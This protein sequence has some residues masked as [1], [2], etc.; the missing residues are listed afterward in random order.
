MRLNA[1]KLVSLALLVFSARALADPIQSGVNFLLQNQS[2]VGAFGEAVGEEPVVTTYEALLTLR[3]TG[4]GALS[5]AQ[6]AELYL[7]TSLAPIDSELQL[8]RELALAGSGFALQP[9]ELFSEGPGFE[10]S[11]ALH[12]SLSLKAFRQVSL[13]PLGDAQAAAVQLAGLARADGCYAFVENDPSPE[14]TADIVSAFRSYSFNPNVNFAYQAALNCLRNLQRGD[15]SW[16]SVTSTASAVLALLESSG[17]NAVAISSGRNF[18]IATQLANGSWPGGVRATA[19]ATHALIAG[20]PDWR[21]TTDE[22]GRPALVLS[23]PEPLQGTTFTASFDVENR[24][25]TAAPT[26]NVRFIGNLLSGGPD[27]VLANIFIPPLSAGQTTN[28][29]TSLPTAQLG[30]RYILRAIVNPDNTI[31]ELDTTNNTAA[32]QLNVRQENDLAVSAAGIRFTTLGPNQVQVSV[33]V[34]NYGTTLPINVGVD[35]YKGSPFSGGTRV[36]S[37]TINAGLAPNQGTTVTVNW[38]T[39]TVNGPTAVYAFVDP[40]TQLVEADKNNNIAFRFFYPGNQASTDLAVNASEWTVSPPRPSPRQRFTVSVPV[41]NL[42]AADANRVQVTIY[43]ASSGDTLSQVELSQVPATGITVAQFAVSLPFVAALRATVDPQQLIQDP[44]RSNNTDVLGSFMSSTSDVELTMSDLNASSTPAPGGTFTVN[45]SVLNS[46][47]Q[48]ANTSIRLVDETDGRQLALV[49]LVLPGGTSAS[50]PMGPIV[51]LSRPMS[52][53]AC[54]DP[55]NLISEVNK[56]D[57]CLEVVVSDTFADV[58]LRAHDIQIAPVGADVGESVHLSATFRSNP[59]VSTS[60]VVEWWQ[61]RPTN[62]EGVLIGT[63]PIQINAGVGVA[64]FD[65]VRKDGV[66]EVHARMTGDGVLDP[67]RRNNQ[68]GRHL[69]LDSIVDVGVPGAAGEELRFGR[70]TGRAAP[71]MVLGYSFT[72]PGPFGATHSWIAVLQRNP[73]GS[74]AI[75]WQHELLLSIQDIVLGDLDGDGIPEVVAFSADAT[76]TPV[77]RITAYEPDGSTKWEQNF[78]GSNGCIASALGQTSRGL[79][80]GDVNGDGVADLVYID[81]NLRVFSGRDGA[82]LLN[83]ALTTSGNCVD[84]PTTVLDVDGTGAHEIFG[85]TGNREAFLMNSDGT[86]RWR[87]PVPGGS[88]YAIIDLDLSGSP[89]IVFPVHRNNLIAFDALTGNQVQTGSPF[90]SH[91]APFGIGSVRQDGLPYVTMGDNSFDSHAAA[92]GPDLQLIW[93]QFNSRFNASDDIAAATTTLA[94]LLG[95]GRPQLLLHNAANPLMIEDGRDGRIL[96]P[97]VTNTLGLMQF[98][99]MHP[100]TAVDFRGDGRSGVAIPTQT[101][102]NPNWPGNQGVDYAP[103]QV[104]IFSSPHWNK[105]P[106][107]WNARRIVK[108]RVDENLRVSTDYRW[109]RTNNTWNQQFDQQPVVLLADLLVRSGDISASPTPGTSGNAT[110]ITAQISNVGGLAASNV[111]VSFYDGDPNAGGRLIADSVVAGPL[112]PRTGRAPASVTWT[113]YPEGQ[114]RLFVVA[115]S[116]GAIQESGRENNTASIAYFVQPGTQLCDLAIDPTGLSANPSAPNA[117]DSVSLSASVKNI[118]VIPCGATAL[119]VY[120]GAPAEGGPLVGS[121]PIPSLAVQQS[122]VFTVSTI[123]EPGTHLFRFIADE[124]MLV[125]DGDRS[126]NTAMLQLFVPPSSTSDLIVTSLAAAPNPAFA[127]ETVVLSATVRNLGASAGATDFVVTLNSSTGTVL[128][129]GALPPLRPGETTNLSIPIAA[130]AASSQLFLTVNP[131]RRVTEFNYNNNTLSVAFALADPGLVVTGSANPSSAG[132][133][134]NVLFTVRLQ[135][136]SPLAR[137]VFVDASAIAPSGA[138]QSTLASSARYVVP[139]SSITT[140]NLTWNTGTSSPGAYRL[141]AAVRNS[142]RQVAAVDASVVVTAEQLVT[143]SIVT[144]RGSYAPGGTVL[145]NQRAS[146]ASR[147]QTLTGATLTVSVLDAIGRAL[148][149]STRPVPAIPPQG[150]LDTADLFSIS[151]SL[152][153]GNYTA[154]SRLNDALGGLLSQAQVGWQLVYQATQTVTGTETVTSP[155]AVGQVLGVSVQ[156]QNTGAVALSNGQLQATIFNATSFAPEAGASIA[157]NLAAGQTQTFVVNVNTAAISTGPKLVVASLDGRVLDRVMAQAVPQIHINPPVI[158]VRGVS[159]LLV[160]NQAVTPTITITSDSAFTSIILLDSQ[161]YVSGT[162]VSSNG[163]HV[164]FISATDVFGNHAEVAIRFT[165]STAAPT[166]TITGVSEGQASRSATPVITVTDTLQVTVVTTLNGQPFTSG[167]AITTDGLYV[168]RVEATD[169]AGNQTVKV[170]N[171]RITNV[172]PVITITGV[173]DGQVSNHALTPVIAVTDV[174]GVSSVATLNGNPFTS[175]TAVGAEGDYTL[176]V[177]ATD[178]AGNASSSVVHFAIDVTPPVI[179]ITGVTDRQATRQ[180]VTPVITVTDAHPGTNTITLNGQPFVSGTTISAQGLYVLAVAATDAAGNQSTRQLTF[181]IR[182]PPAITV[183]GVVDGALINHAVTPIFSATDLTDVSIVATL[184]GQPFLSGTRVA[185]P[186]GLHTLAV[187]ATD[188]A[189]NVANATVRFTFDFT[190]PVV[191][192]TG[193]A[194]GD[195]SDFFVIT[196]SATD[197]HLDTVLA[198]LDGNPF[199]SGTRVD[200][201]A[202]HTLVVT[203]TDRAG[204]TTTVTRHFTV[205]DM[206]PRFFYAACAF[207]NLSIDSI[208]RVDAF[209]SG[210]GSVATHG[211]LL[212]DNNTTVTGDAVAGGSAT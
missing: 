152:P 17:N 36:G 86:I 194:E 97:Q 6:S 104:L 50:V 191:T 67:D 74:Y 60:G 14:L 156:L 65:W 106:T 193:V 209:S 151:P 89:K 150:F 122:M 116:D 148:Y 198:R 5:P 190:P 157:V 9:F 20:S 121:L 91:D 95:L 90:E 88:N 93:E 127:G 147:N 64:A 139:G 96:V 204:N 47:G 80:L 1:A 35:V 54:V 56:N 69:F 100:L 158:T 171:F 25:G 114:H 41:H 103:G 102:D 202:A 140:A 129:T 166:V 172:P 162:P 138:T 58:F 37:G 111:K 176:N 78:A 70:L 126:N 107:A 33:T 185:G 44:N 39:A 28:V 167:T 137:E 21:I 101:D 153:P 131:S 163:Q 146:N 206:R 169:Q 125:L 49:P 73:D 68:N 182:V 208:A 15:G 18:L 186:E 77:A 109:W 105:M 79:G 134:T 2:P 205:V 59:P 85:I 184:D 31:G 19:L 98:S 192:V 174:V 13:S 168:L 160:T 200:A 203:A 177:S 32:A 12:L 173:S 53:K 118:G 133:A 195:T 23:N 87:Q 30:G 180:S 72:D 24:S 212:M 10:Q 159:D 115:N 3:A 196:F 144:D 34:N 187:T 183:S 161:P 154:A 164:L 71:E 188:T 170:V 45:A 82:Q 48:T 210:V 117:G 8:R 132:P 119:T 197:L 128:A 189:G 211:N 27:V 63:T 55:F 43:N 108:G 123:A 16:G 155:F 149:T 207:G 61:G 22:L 179:T 165:I 135:N 142:G 201:I 51:R 46:G 199:A 75:L 4:A 124:A 130:P 175:G 110:T 84:A 7:A 66:P 143:T 62:P 94:D 40:T 11:D 145:I 113:A 52:M 181:A 26:I 136:A 141:H 120:D 83:V 29:S 112:P 38:N 92:F 57:N 42:S 76:T 99:R 178:A 81:D